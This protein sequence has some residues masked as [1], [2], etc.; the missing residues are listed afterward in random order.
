MRANPVWLTELTEPRP[1]E[2]PFMVAQSGAPGSQFSLARA[3]QGHLVRPPPSPWKAP[4][5]LPLPADSGWTGLRRDMPALLPML[6]MWLPPPPSVFLT[7]YPPSPC[8]ASCLSPLGGTGGR[9]LW[10]EEERPG[11]R[12]SSQPG[13][14]DNKE[15][16]DG[17]L[18]KCGPKEMGA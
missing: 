18:R 6:T 4:S 2:S 1:T 13:S 8:P 3:P 17:R 12:C 16:G 11:S 9:K 10:E 14:A 5:S 15:D 7:W